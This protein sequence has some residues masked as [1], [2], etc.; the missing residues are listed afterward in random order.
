MGT[1]RRLAI[2]ADELFADAVIGQFRPL[3]D[4]KAATAN[5][6]KQKS[7]PVRAAFCSISRNTYDE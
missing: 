4:F 5:L 6:R 1:A 7:R 2:R 3:R